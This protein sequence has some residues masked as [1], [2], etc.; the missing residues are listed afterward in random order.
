MSS[1]T[2]QIREENEAL[3]EFRPDVLLLAAKV[4]EG[5]SP[6]DITDIEKIFRSAE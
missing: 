5:L 6:D 1:D 3:A 4:Y 2:N